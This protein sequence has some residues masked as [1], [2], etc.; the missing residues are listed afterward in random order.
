MVNLPTYISF[1]PLALKTDGSRSGSDQ[2]NSESGPGA[3]KTTLYGSDQTQILNTGY[4]G[5]LLMD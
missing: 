2:N 1:R 5:V 4:S 3:W